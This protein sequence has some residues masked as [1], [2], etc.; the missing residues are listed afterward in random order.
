MTGNRPVWWSFARVLVALLGWIVMLVWV[1]PVG[2]LVFFLA[3]SLIPVFD[4][5]GVTDKAHSILLPLAVWPM[6]LTQQ[7]IQKLDRR[8]KT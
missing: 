1:C 2:F 3:L 6:V 5:L 8:L 4:V 7:I